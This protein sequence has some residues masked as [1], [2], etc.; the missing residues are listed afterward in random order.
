VT[1]NWVLDFT[2]DHFAADELK[3]QKSDEFLC[4]TTV[5]RPPDGPTGDVR[6]RLEVVV[7]V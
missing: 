5:H 4:R 2:P 3:K 1:Y 6:E 7:T